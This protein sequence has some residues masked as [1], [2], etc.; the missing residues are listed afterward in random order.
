MVPM[1]QFISSIYDSYNKSTLLLNQ[2]ILPLIYYDWENSY[3]EAAAYVTL[4]TSKIREAIQNRE[5]IYTAKEHMRSYLTRYI[6]LAIWYHRD[7]IRQVR[8]EKFALE[9]L[10]SLLYE[11]GFCQ[12]DELHQATAWWDDVCMTCG[13]PTSLDKTQTEMI[14]QIL[15]LCSLSKDIHNQLL[16][17]LKDNKQAHQTQEKKAYMISL[18][19]DQFLR[20]PKWSEKL[21][22]K[23]AYGVDEDK[24]AHL[25]RFIHKPQEQLPHFIAKTKGKQNISSPAIDIANL[26][27]LL[28]SHNW[29]SENLSKTVNEHYGVVIREN[30]PAVASPFLS[31]LKPI[32]NSN[33]SHPITLMMLSYIA[34]IVSGLNQEQILD[35]IDYLRLK[36][37]NEWINLK[38][39]NPEANSSQTATY[40]KVE[41]FS[42][43]LGLKE[44]IIH[45][46]HYNEETF[47]K[48][49]SGLKINEDLSLDLLLSYVSE[50]ILSMVEVYN[51]ETFINAQDTA[52]MTRHLV[53]YGGS[54]DYPEVAPV[55]DYTGREVLV[56]P[57]KGTNGQTLSLYFDKE[58][59]IYVI[60]SNHNAIFE[61]ILGNIKEEP[62]LINVRVIIDVGCHF[63]GKT[64]NEVAEIIS[65]NNKNPDVHAVVFFDHNSGL[66]SFVYANNPKTKYSIQGTMLTDILSQT[67]CELK[68]LFF[69]I[70]GFHATATNLKMIPFSISIVTCNVGTMHDDF[71]QGG[72]RTREWHFLQNVIVALDSSSL[73]KIS[74]TLFKPYIASLP[75]GRISN[76]REVMKDIGLYTNLNTK[77]K[78]P[79]NVYEICLHKVRSIPKTFLLHLIHKGQVKSEHVFSLCSELFTRKNSQQLIDSVSKH[80]GMKKKEFFDSFINS[81]VGIIEQNN[82]QLGINPKD[83]AIMKTTMINTVTKLLPKMNDE[84]EEFKKDKQGGLLHRNNI[85]DIKFQNKNNVKENET[86]AITR[87]VKHTPYNEEEINILYRYFQG[88]RKECFV[89][90][91]HFFKQKNPKNQDIFHKNLFFNTNFFVS[92]EAFSSKIIEPYQIFIKPIHTVLLIR[93]NNEHNKPTL[94][95]IVG[96]AADMD[97]IFKMA[98]NLNQ[99]FLLANHIP[100]AWIIKTEGEC[101]KSIN[102]PYNFKEL[103]DIDNLNHMLVQIQFIAGQ[104]EVLKQKMWLTELKKWLDSLKYT[105][106]IFLK[107]WFEKSIRSYGLYES[108]ESSPLVNVWGV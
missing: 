45:I 78:K 1:H 68:Q 66:L 95:I 98:Q 62:R 102:A 5:L 85:S 59:T 49:I 69:F 84:T 12:W 64:N 24:L 9:K 43:L 20:D 81:L 36:I 56:V 61:T 27:H 4:L 33:F 94:K 58:A 47:L 38:L 3:N 15:K 52:P 105:N 11:R 65:I 55:M 46:L 90:F 6:T 53:G 57:L 41:K 63:N 108:Y 93:D 103:N 107:E 51:E 40:V 54:M 87:H 37:H 10:L 80:E 91:N 70:D 23:T 77:S 42:A 14:A 21:G 67:K 99:I 39:S 8:D 34:Y 92:Q 97:L 60:D 30:A 86:T 101:Y 19:V 89:N 13:E 88:I 2:P 16:V 72:K 83:I 106:R 74:S 50:R 104:V 18:I 7:K 22:L 29:L 31:H 75:R 96:S 71:I 28:I 73:S 48:I 79:H 35:F 100:A 82:V 26:L 25:K 32:E 76:S 44:N 17:L